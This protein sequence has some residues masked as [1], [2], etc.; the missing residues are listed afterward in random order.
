[1]EQAT[2]IDP[3]IEQPDRVAVGGQH[4]DAREVAVLHFGGDCGA[5]SIVVPELVADRLVGVLTEADVVRRRIPPDPLSTTV[6]EVMSS[7]P[8]TVN[9]EAASWAPS[10]RGSGGCSSPGR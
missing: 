5:D 1:M 9:P 10:W 8:L 6:G 3:G 2:L 7:S 4:V